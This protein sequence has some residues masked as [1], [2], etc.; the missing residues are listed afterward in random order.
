MKIKRPDFIS[1][2]TRPSTETFDLKIPKR[3]GIGN[4]TIR[5]DNFTRPP[6]K[7]RTPLFNKTEISY[8]QNIKGKVDLS[9]KT[10]SELF[11][12]DIP[13]ERDILWLREKDRLKLFYK[14]KGFT[15]NE[16]KLELQYHKPL[17]RNQRTIRKRDNI[18]TSKL[19]FNNKIDEIEQEIREGRGLDRDRLE[20][21]YQ[22]LNEIMGDISAI[23]NMSNTQLQDL[24]KLIEKI[25]IPETHEELN[26]A[27]FVGA[28]YYK[29]NAGIINMFLIRNSRRD[30][31]LTLN[32]PIHG[33]TENGRN[34]IAT[35]NASLGSN[36]YYLDLHQRRM[37]NWG[38]LKNIINDIPN[39][40]ENPS[41]QI[42]PT[43]LAGSI[44]NIDD[45]QIQ[46]EQAL[47]AQSEAEVQGEIE[48]AQ[49]E[50][51]E[52]IKILIS[53]L[54][55]KIDRRNNR[56]EVVKNDLVVVDRE[57]NNK[58]PKPPTKKQ[59]S[60]KKE[61]EQEIKDLTKEIKDLTNELKNY[62]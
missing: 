6:V 40:W 21:I 7:E 28:S 19:S 61:A 22:Q 39:K 15:D 18:G 27:R 29:K 30:S 33:T 20:V 4:F 3:V 47:E 11:D 37:L 26:L 31:S 51:A 56:L 1:G 24:Y 48:G 44:D 41:V 5:R 16:I 42:L 52:Q 62:I 25:N 2:N 58:L 12:V 57:I 55:R 45:E 50:E 46:T 10:L 49:A 36:R 9:D 17:G 13:D 54:K 32:E 60:R 23:N 35:M 14:N 8:T 53:S 59:K 38:Q 34:T 43:E